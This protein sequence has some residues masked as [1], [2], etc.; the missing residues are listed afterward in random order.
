MTGG[1]R[2]INL[3][4]TNADRMPF[5]GGSVY[6]MTKAALVG[7]VKGLARDLGPR[8]ITI[9]NIQPG[10][11]ETDMNP[12]TG[13]FAKLMLSLMALPRYGSVDEIASLIAYLARPLCRIHHRGQPD[14]RW[15]VQRLASRQLTYNSNM[16]PRGSNRKRRDPH[17]PETT[18]P[19]RIVSTQRSRR[20][21]I[22]FLC[23]ASRNPNFPGSGVSITAI[24][25]TAP[26]LNAPRSF[27]SSALAGF[28][29]V[30]STS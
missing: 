18:A 12:A 25:A 10:P 27:R 26:S 20:S 24:S 1:G 28:T 19:F 16:A 13:D 11:I 8:G 23:S 5:P 9:N 22:S 6:A 3:G 17:Y 21:P 14:D 4:S 30:R 7:L 29:V 15:R 2:I